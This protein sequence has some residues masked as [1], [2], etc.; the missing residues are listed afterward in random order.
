MI[1]AQANLRSVQGA[2]APST[3]PG[4]D[5]RTA[6]SQCHTGWHP[7]SEYAFN[8]LAAG[9]VQKLGDWTV[10]FNSLAAPIW[11]PAQTPFDKSQDVL[12]AVFIRSDGYVFLT[13]T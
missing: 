2:K 5:L 13:A 1:A 8:Q 9:G 10:P 4:L 3:G 11:Q 12:V 6:T 7:L